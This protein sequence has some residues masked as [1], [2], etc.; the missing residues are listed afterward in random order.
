MYPK[1]A[2]EIITEYTETTNMSLEDSELM[3]Y[4]Y[5]RTI[6]QKA[7]A[8]DQHWNLRIFGLG[9][10]KASYSKV[11]DG[12]YGNRTKKHKAS[13]EGNQY[14]YDSSLVKIK[15]LLSIMRLFRTEKIRQE[16]WKVKKKKYREQRNRK[17]YATKRDPRT[18]MEEPGTDS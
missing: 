10:L 13:K 12:F 5:Y 7:S 2:K 4:H 17:D 8:M 16:L 6:R 11:I 15:Q 3:I 18:G 14:E 1:K 9:S